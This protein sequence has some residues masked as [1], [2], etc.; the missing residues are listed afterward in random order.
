LIESQIDQFLAGGKHEDMFPHRWLPS[1]F[2][3]IEEGF[4]E[5]NQLLNSTMKIVRPKINE[6]FKNNIAYMYTPAGKNIFNDQ[7]TNTL[8]KILM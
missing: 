8:K 7:N 4:T 1:T 3:I 5:D 2:S 6:H